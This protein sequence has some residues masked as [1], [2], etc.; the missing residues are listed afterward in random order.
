M[1]NRLWITTAMAAT[2]GI[3][4]LAWA[5][6]PRPL[7]GSSKDPSASQT[8]RKFTP[9]PPSLIPVFTSA[10][11]GAAGTGLRNRQSATINLSGVIP[12]VQAAYLY[13]GVINP[14]PPPDPAGLSHVIFREIGGT[15]QLI[16]GTL[17][18]T[19]PSPC[20][21]GDHTS[22]Y[23]ALVT[24]QT[25]GNGLYEVQVAPPG[26]GIIDGS[27]PWVEAN[28]TLPQWEGASLVVVGT[29]TNT[30]NITDFIAG[31]P[32]TTP[33]VPPFSYTVNLYGT[34]SGADAIWTTINADGQVGTSVNAQNNLYDEQVTINGTQVSGP[35]EGPNAHDTDS[36]YNGNDASPLPQLW[37]TRTHD[38][39][40]AGVTG[41]VESGS[42]AVTVSSLSGVP[43][44][45]CIE[46]VANVI[47]F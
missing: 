26:V 47:S 3:G 9:R 16:T 42:L 38:L 21:G 29:G 14:N 23:R 36:D 33:P 19:A 34:P 28:S 2:L 31:T 30:V 25:S 24:S 32:L 11:Y 15:P 6:Q 20:W 27:D 13:W 43:P 8:V 5:Q 18:A 39:T 37:D 45:D 35:N 44:L 46:V 41:I 1:K 40:T 4:S 12:P 7:G 17:L 22:Y 10:Q